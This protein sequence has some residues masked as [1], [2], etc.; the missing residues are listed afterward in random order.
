MSIYKLVGT[1]HPQKS[2]PRRHTP[3]PISAKICQKLPKDISKLFAIMLVGRKWLKTAQKWSK[4]GVLV[5]KVRMTP[6]RNRPRRHTPIGFDQNPLFGRFRAVFI[7]FR[8]TNIIEK[9][10]EM[11]LGSFWQILTD[12]GLGVCGPGT[13][14]NLFLQYPAVFLRYFCSIL[15]YFTAFLQ[16]LIIKTPL[17]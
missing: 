10:F 12:I 7:H 4:K 9:S 6:P 5:E 16:Y 17:I 2:A 3:S 1:V 13:D 14:C 11:S 15:Q 8:P